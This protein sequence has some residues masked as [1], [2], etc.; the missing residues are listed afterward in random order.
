MNSG[1]TCFSAKLVRNND[2]DRDSH[3]LECAV[4]V[5]VNLAKLKITFTRNLT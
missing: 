3:F 2:I 1:K 5:A 4:L